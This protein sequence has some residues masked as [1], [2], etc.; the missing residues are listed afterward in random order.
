MLSCNTLKK[1]MIPAVLM[2]AVLQSACGPGD[3]NSLTL[4]GVAP[5]TGS[6]YG[7]TMLT[8]TG[9][10][11]AA[12]M[13]INVGPNNCTPVTV[14]SDTQA[15]CRTVAHA[16]GPV[17]VVV[18][19]RDSTV[20]S[21]LPDAF[22]YGCV[23]PM[24]ITGLQIWA[25]DG[26]DKVTQD[27]QRAFCDPVAQKNSVWDGTTIKLFGAKNEVVAFNLVLEAIKAAA[28]NVSVSF[29]TLNGPG[30]S[31]IRSVPANPTGIFDWTNRNIEL[32]YV[33][34]LQI[35][36]L[37]T[38][39]YGSI[40]ERQVPKR[41]QRPWTGDGLANGGWLDRP[42]HNKFYP[43]IAVPLELEPTFNIA[44]GQNQSIW[45]DIFIPKNSAPGIYT[46]NVTVSQNGTTVTTVPVQLTVRGFALPDVPSSK[47]MVYL[48]YA[49][50]SERYYGQRYVDNDPVKGPG[51]DLIRDRHFQMAHR[52]K[53][54]MIDENDPWEASEYG[55]DA[56]R[57]VWLPRLNGSLF[58][59]AKGY[60]GPGIGTGNGIYTVG[61]YG[62]WTWSHT[63][64]QE[65]W[66]HTNAWESWFIANSPSTTR[67]MFLEDEPPAS[68]YAQIQQWNKWIHENPGPGSTIR[69]FVATS[70]LDA[71]SSLN[72][73]A[74][75]GSTIGQGDTATWQTALDSWKAK[76]KTFMMYNGKRPA[77]GTFAT[78]A[79]GLDLREIPWGQF[80][81]GVDRWFFWESTYYNDYQY[82]RSE[83]NLFHDAQTFGT[84]DYDDSSLGRTG[85]NYMNGNGV[86]FYPG[87]DTVHQADSYGV[88]GPIASIRL[89]L[90]RR[91]IQDVDYLTLAMAK[92]PART[93]AI[94]D[95]LV[96]KVLWEN[97]VNEINDPSFVKAP[98]GWSANPD[99]WE[100]ARAQLADIIEGL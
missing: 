13:V 77:S 88:E 59:A 71:N 55:I 21:S 36:G 16:A 66:D 18:M 72:G 94:I 35:N 63:D 9:V 87:T 51:L 58:T 56:P 79:E 44:A 4:E 65:M 41:L 92:S 15:T 7:N 45:T 20:V 50:L 93:K 42:D 64:E 57:A 19:S 49:D 75:V 68:D 2:A 81:K 46:G 30:G 6:I 74:S 28:P 39:G 80:K 54:A 5:L 95:A 70:L 62:I 90:W 14:V 78:E 69:T 26:S 91:G 98:L 11:F 100:A 40:D 67:Y 61:T 86:L 10:N 48:G 83:N 23:A 96:P 84:N 85:S 29:D 99:D 43:D 33:R 73:L 76:G 37:S 22:T 8:L 27:E 32:F 3:P 53:I 97:G 60:D 17:D 47:T 12:G 34:Y 52:H 38:S 82:G 89:K 24:G 31:V 25:N 1:L